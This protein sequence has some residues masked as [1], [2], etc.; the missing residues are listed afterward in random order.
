MMGLRHCRDRHGGLTVD[1]L[2]RFVFQ[3]IRR[4]IE[5]PQAPYF[6]YQPYETPV[7]IVAG[8]S[9]PPVPFPPGPKV[10]FRRC[11]AGTP[12][13]LRDGNDDP[14]FLNPPLVAGPGHVQLPPLADG[15]YLLESEADPGMAVYFR[16]P[17]DKHVIV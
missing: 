6:E 5:Q 9:G 4:V 11:A 15:L 12:F 13:I 7:V 8:T 1:R 17:G 14:V 16:Q 3:N 10:E 2:H